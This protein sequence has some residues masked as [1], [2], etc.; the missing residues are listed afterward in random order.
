[1]GGTNIT[2]NG[3]VD[4]V[5][6]A[7]SYS[8]YQIKS[9][10]S[11]TLITEGSNIATMDVLQGI[12][13]IQF[14]NGI[15]KIANGT[16]ASNT[17]TTGSISS[18]STVIQ[19]DTNS[20]GSTTLS[21][22]DSQFYLSSSGPDPALQ[23]A[24]AAVTAGEFGAWTP[25]GA[26]QT[27]SGYDVAWK[28]TA[29]GQYTVWTTD[30]N[31]NYTGNLTGAAGQGQLRIGIDRACVPARPKRRRPHRSDRDS[32]PDRRVYQPDGDCEPILP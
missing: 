16:F 31:G 14:S 23:Y 32:D 19:K 24:G 29:T 10:G 13:Y 30:S 9:S 21:E 4:T 1:M 2:G 12:S 7:S 6:Y 22:S 11:Q 17:G 5:V 15:Y 8:N 20:F 25:I 18:T 3:A 27:A 26:V 28:N